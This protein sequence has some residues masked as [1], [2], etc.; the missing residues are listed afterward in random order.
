MRPQGI[1]KLV[2]LCNFC[3]EKSVFVQLYL[4]LETTKC[5]IE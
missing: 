5:H 2:D 4:L 3:L 1:V